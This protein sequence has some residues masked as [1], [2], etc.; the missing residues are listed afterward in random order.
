MRDNISIKLL[1]CEDIFPE[2]LFG[3][4][5]MQV[6]TEKWVKDGSGFKLC[7]T[8]EVREWDDEKRIWV[9]E[10]LKEQIKRDGYTVA[11]FCNDKL[12][13]FASLDGGIEVLNSQK[14]ANLT[15][16]FIDERWR[17]KGVGKKLFMKL[18]ECAAEKGAD[19]V[20]I[21]AISSLKTVAFYFGIG[22]CDAETVIENFIDTEEDRYM[23]YTIK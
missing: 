5:D 22:C 15:M 21:S 20:F 13:G 19:K 16:M 17:R 11:A 10:Y 7:K 6:I 12:I 18:C 9:T 2:M 23:E 4:H 8:N 14:Y 3:F 1:T